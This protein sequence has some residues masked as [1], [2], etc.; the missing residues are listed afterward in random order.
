MQIK[1]INPHPTPLPPL[2]KCPYYIKDSARYYRM[3]PDITRAE[4]DRMVEEEVNRKL[5]IHFI[6]ELGY[7]VAPFFSVRYGRNIMMFINLWKFY[8]AEVYWHDHWRML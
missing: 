1:P 4:F 6:D 8:D 2:K 5:K 3:H 7:L